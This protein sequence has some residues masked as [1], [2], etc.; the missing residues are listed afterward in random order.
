MIRL[1]FR[2]GEGRSPEV[3]GE[4]SGHRALWSVPGCRTNSESARSIPSA[5]GG[6]GEAFLAARPV[7]PSPRKNGPQERL[8]PG[9]WRL[10]IAPEG[11]GNRP[12]NFTRIG[13]GE[14][15][16]FEGACLSKMRIYNVLRAG[17]GGLIRPIPAKESVTLQAHKW[18]RIRTLS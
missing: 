6:R 4:D 7:Y 11:E 10:Q 8:E 2:S 16:G 1:S 3:S 9:F 17:R 18:P 15:A 12:L 13:A 5:T 14:Q